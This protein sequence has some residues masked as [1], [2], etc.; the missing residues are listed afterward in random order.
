LHRT[1]NYFWRLPRTIDRNKSDRH[2][3]ISDIRNS[4]QLLTLFQISK[5]VVCDMHLFGYLKWL[6]W[7]SEIVIFDIQ[8]NYSGY[9]KLCQKGVLFQ[10]SKNSYFWYPEFC[11]Q[12][13]KMN[14]SVFWISKIMTHQFVISKIVIMD[15]RNNY[16]GYPKYLFWISKIRTCFGIFKIVFFQI[17]GIIISDIW[18][19]NKC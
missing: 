19:M 2:A 7:I 4:W 16:F 9:Q 14:V 17:S 15:I 13:S 3:T 11:F 12:I 1:V 6:F 5:I 18:K 10:I 8:N